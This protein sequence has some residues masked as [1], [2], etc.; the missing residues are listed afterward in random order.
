[1]DEN[2]LSLFSKLQS[3]Q[4][5]Q[6]LAS[7]NDLSARY[8]LTL[9]QS[10]MR[11][12]SLARAQSLRETGRVEFGGGILPKLIYAFCD[13]PYIQSD[14]YEATLAELQDAFYYIKG[15]ALEQYSDDELIEYM[16]KAFNGPAE[17]SVDY[18]TGST[19]EEL[20]RLAREGWRDEGR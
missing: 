17:G 9:T 5:E 3:V 2:A 1:M 6:E 14:E 13:S 19:L 16:Q 10:E 20:A 12:L 15:E 7:C 18:L 4:T 8:G 11:E